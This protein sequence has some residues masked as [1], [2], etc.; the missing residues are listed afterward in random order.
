M[1]KLSI[2]AACLA[3]SVPAFAY[4]NTITKP[5]LIVDPVTGVV[6]G[7]THVV[8]GVT[9]GAFGWASGATR[10]TSNFLTT[11]W[12]SGWNQSAMHQDGKVYYGINNNTPYLVN[13][14]GVQ[15]PGFYR[16]HKGTHYTITNLDNG[17]KYR[18]VHLKTGTMDV[19][20]GNRMIR[21]Q[22]VQPTV[23]PL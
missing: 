10:G 19:M 6:E 21:Y 3:L 11:G 14:T 22:Y 18:V 16:M 5:A 9:T 13:E 12:N 4:T 7:T 17:K 23:R 8:T 20:H 15:Y 1:K 2:A